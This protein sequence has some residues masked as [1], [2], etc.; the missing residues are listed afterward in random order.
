MLPPATLW[1]GQPG[2]MRAEIAPAAV[3]GA[4]AG[5]LALGLA[6]PTPRW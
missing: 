1:T 3:V 2:G 4:L 5:T 6:L